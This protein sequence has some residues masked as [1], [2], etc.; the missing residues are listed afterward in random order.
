MGLV[1]SATVSYYHIQ[2]G[3]QELLLSGSP[4]VLYPWLAS[5]ATVSYYHTQVGNLELVL[6]GSPWGFPDQYGIPYLS[7]H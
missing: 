4:C 6:S 3:N 2:V 5:S 1:S 7:D